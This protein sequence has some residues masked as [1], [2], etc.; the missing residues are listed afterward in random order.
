MTKAST[1]VVESCPRNSDDECSN[2]SPI[3]YECLRAH[4][5]YDPVTTHAQSRADTT[6]TLV[7][8]IADSGGIPGT[9]D[10]TAASVRIR[11]EAGQ[12]YPRKGYY[13][14]PAKV[15]SRRLFKQGEVMSEFNAKYGATIWQWD[16]NQS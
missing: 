3:P 16:Q 6:W 8:R 14:T 1:S 15:D 12:T 5:G 4:V 10:E 9:T 2:R 11:V 7:E 13:F